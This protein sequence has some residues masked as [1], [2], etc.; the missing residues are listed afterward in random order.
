MFTKIIKR[1]SEIKLQ[2]KNNL[3]IDTVLYA[4]LINTLLLLISE[5]MLYIQVYTVVQPHIYRLESR[6]TLLQLSESFYVISLRRETD[7]TRCFVD[8][9][10]DLINMLWVHKTNILEIITRKRTL[11]KNL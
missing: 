1:E 4:Y 10:L 7:I 11:D 3:T 2:K 5:Y 6:S 8:F 9:S